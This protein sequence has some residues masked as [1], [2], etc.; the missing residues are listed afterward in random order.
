MTYPPKS[1]DYGWG[2]T[3]SGIIALGPVREAR[4]VREGWFRKREIPAAVWD[5]NAGRIVEVAHL[6]EWHSLDE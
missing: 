6:S 5:M 2:K 4:T 1:G 3:A